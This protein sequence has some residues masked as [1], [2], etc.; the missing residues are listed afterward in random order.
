L[1]KLLVL[2]LSTVGGALGWSLGAAIG[3]MT[4]FF[5]SLA[6]TGLGVYAGVR[7]ARQLLG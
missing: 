3:P 6:G 7:V 1:S 4:A 5:V 2:V